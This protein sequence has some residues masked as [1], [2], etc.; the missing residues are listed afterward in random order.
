[1]DSTSYG[2]SSQ[3]VICGG[4]DSSHIYEKWTGVSSP[5]FK[6]GDTVLFKLDST[7]NKLTMKHTRRRR[8]FDIDIAP[9]CASSSVH[10]KWQ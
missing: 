1:M 4:Y 3:Q 10:S 6:Q 2:W 5:R 8:S 7:T 9:P